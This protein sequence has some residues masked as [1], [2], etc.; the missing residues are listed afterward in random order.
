MNPKL[1]IKTQQYL[2]DAATENN[3]KKLLRLQKKC[4]H[5]I[6]FKHE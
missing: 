6:A 2:Q 1:V 3:Y 4:E 5:D